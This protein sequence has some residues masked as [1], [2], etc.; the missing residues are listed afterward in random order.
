[1]SRVL[2]TGGASFIG[3]HLVEELVL[4]GDEVWVV[5]NLSSGSLE[6][7]GSVWT[8]IRFMGEDLRDAGAAL[9][10]TPPGIDAVFHLAAD[11]GGRG[12]VE[13]R[14]VACAINFVLDQ[15]VFRAALERNVPKIIFASSGCVYPMYKQRSV[16]ELMYLR[17][18]EVGPPYDPDGLYGFAKL[19]G[20]LFLRE[21]TK[22]YGTKTASCRFFTVYG[23]RGKENHAVI[24]MIARAF[25]RQDPFEI[26][27]DGTQV[28]N[29]THVDDIVEGMLAC[30]KQL[31]V[32]GSEDNIELNIGTLERTTVLEA[33]Q[34]VVASSRTFDGWTSYNPTFSFAKS[35]P[36]GPLN[37][38]ADN[39]KL[40]ELTGHQ[41]KPFRFGVDEVLKW[42]FST[43]DPE[44]IA[45][46]LE[47]LLIE[48]KASLL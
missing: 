38:V 4:R 39:T 1:M 45:A 36:V 48:R 46:H 21:L 22:E 37:R 41:M 3:S 5:D 2:V 42:Y 34:M 9:A 23:P 13:L 16:G 10:A 20:E 30:E 18:D 24:A 6:N 43:K 27:G 15:N 28:R 8:D 32:A 33:V 11:H 17:E 47:E 26:W 19:A 40:L 12:Y 14:Q 31:D 25:V 35:K 7:L 44:Y 29:W